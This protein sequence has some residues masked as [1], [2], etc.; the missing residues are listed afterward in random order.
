MVPEIM[1][2]S[3]SSETGPCQERIPAARASASS[4]ARVHRLFV[5]GR[6]EA[7]TAARTAHTRL[8]AQP[9]H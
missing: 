6:S 9:V 7:Q 3:G 2:A 1:P 4:P 5:Q 8:S